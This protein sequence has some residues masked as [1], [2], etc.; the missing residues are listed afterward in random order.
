MEDS[1]N[2]DLVKE[3]ILQ[4][5]ELVPEAYHQ[6][7]REYRKIPAQS[8][9]DFASKKSIL[10]DR[11]VAACQ[12]KNFSSL[13]C[14]W[15]SLRCLTD[16]LVTHLNEQ[17]VESLAKAAVMAEDFSMTHKSFFPSSVRC[18]PPLET[19]QERGARKRIIL[20]E[21]CRARHRTGHVIANCAVLKVKNERRN[22][23]QSHSTREG[24]INSVDSSL[25]PQ[26][27]SYEA[28]AAFRLFTCGSAM[29]VPHRQEQSVTVLKNTVVAPS[30]LL[31]EALPVSETIDFVK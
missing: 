12:A 8:Y 15:K 6:R 3:T 16:R 4:A 9:V 28:E 18:K 13:Q 10:F 7:F 20:W 31:T 17:K 25:S 21:L 29:S 11:W 30:V 27:E 22:G 19:S 5:Y 23:G 14:S 2:Y 1:L 24:L 26:S